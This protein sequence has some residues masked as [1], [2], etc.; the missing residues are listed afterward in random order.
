V[1]LNL[2]HPVYTRSHCSQY[3]STTNIGLQQF[4]R[5]PPP[6]FLFFAGFRDQPSRS[7]IY[8]APTTP[9]RGL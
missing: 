1:S 4:D 6:I 8:T 3:Y 2:A 5:Q 9:D 7:K